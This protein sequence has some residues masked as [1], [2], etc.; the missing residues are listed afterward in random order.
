VNHERRERAKER[1][2]GYRND[3]RADKGKGRRA[4]TLVS[5]APLARPCSATAPRSS[6]GYQ[7]SEMEA[8]EGRRSRS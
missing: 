4:A 3:G 8:G 5:T 1:R 7:G 6:R 2:F